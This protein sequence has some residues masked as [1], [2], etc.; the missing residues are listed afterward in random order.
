MEKLHRG[1]W[2]ACLCLAGLITLAG[3][4]FHSCAEARWSCLRRKTFHVPEENIRPS[5]QRLPSY[6][7]GISW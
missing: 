5:G 6:P 4:S 2:V 3:S 1:G 7:G